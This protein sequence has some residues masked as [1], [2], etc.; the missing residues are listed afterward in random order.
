VVQWLALRFAG[1]ETGLPDTTRGAA[2][3]LELEA[4]AWSTLRVPGEALIWRVE[5]R[6]DGDLAGRSTPA[7]IPA[8]GR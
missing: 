8:A 5:I 2:T 4:T 7:V 6:R 1:V 3:S